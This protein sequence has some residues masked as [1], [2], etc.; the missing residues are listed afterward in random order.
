MMKK[1]IPISAGLYLTALVAAP[2]LAEKVGSVVTTR[3]ILTPNNTIDIEVFDDPKIP[4]SACYLSRA[5]KGGAAS[6]VGIQEDT[7]DASI[8]C[9]QVGPIPDE[10]VKKLRSGSIA[11]GEEVFKIDTSLLFKT[12]QVVR[13]YDP[14]RNVITYLVYSDKLIDGSPK[15]S[16]SVVPIIPW[17]EQ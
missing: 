13:N 2:V 17:P 3:N 9:R 4:G 16:L 15:N 5:V 6:V 11:Q 12:M 1:L 7:S 8:A 10:I 14:N